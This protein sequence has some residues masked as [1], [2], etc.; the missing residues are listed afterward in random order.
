MYYSKKGQP[1]E[2]THCEHVIR[3]ERTHCEHVIR[4]ERTHCEHVIR[5]E[6]T[7]CEHV[8]RDERT[9]CEHV[10]RDERTHCE[11]VIRDERTHC[12][13]VI[14]DERTHCEHVIRD[15]RTHCEHVI[16]DVFMLRNL[17][18]RD[19]CHVGTL[20]LGYSGVPWRQVLPAQNEKDQPNLSECDPAAIMFKP[21]ICVVNMEKAAEYLQI[22]W[23]S[24]LLLLRTTRIY[25]LISTPVA[26]AILLFAGLIITWRSTPN[27]D[28]FPTLN[29]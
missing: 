22:I 28:Q 1:D 11:H 26:Q 24:M 12:E 27:I 25:C 5:D 16:R 7:H 10:I 4:D 6:R 15:E 21:N 17:W 20:S 3:D 9:H 13:H 19:T 29:E 8:I 14:R 18:Q 23:I 2:R